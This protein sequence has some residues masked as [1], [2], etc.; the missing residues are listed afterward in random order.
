MLKPEVINTLNTLTTRQ[1]I[2]EA[3]EFLRGKAKRLATQLVDQF[4]VGQQVQFT[5]KRG[6]RLQGTVKALNQ[7]TLS[8][9]VADPFRGKVTWRVASSLAQ[10]VA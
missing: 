1:E 10:P 2:D 4:Q 9:E 7:T 3:W 8:V 5:G 6:A